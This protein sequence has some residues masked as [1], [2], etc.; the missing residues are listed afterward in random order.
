MIEKRH[1]TCCSRAKLIG[2]SFLMILTLQ[3]IFQTPCFHCG[4][5]LAETRLGLCQ[6]CMAEIQCLT[7]PLDAS[8]YLKSMWALTPYHGP[9][10]TLIRKGKFGSKRRIFM[11]L[12]RLMA[13]CALD[14]PEFDAIVHVPVPWHRKISRG[15]DQAEI[16]AEAIHQF[17]A[18]PHYKVL[19]RYD[20]TKQVSRSK[21]QRREKLLGRFFCIDVQ[22]PARILLVDDT[23]T[24]G[25]TL[26]SCAAVLYQQGAEEIIGFALSSTKC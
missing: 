19:R 10:G 15:F 18:V 11:E 8:S 20:F 24:T 1:S 12:S 7:V 9:M 16:L 5:Q 2:G 13:E 26:E 3:S 22:L 17:L 14:L 25:A 4:D 23:I 21:K 6:Y